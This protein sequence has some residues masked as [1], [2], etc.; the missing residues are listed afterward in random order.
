MTASPLM[1]GTA[2]WSIPRTEAGVFPETGTG[3]CRYAALMTAVE[4][5]TTFYRPHRPATFARWHDSVPPSFRFSV[6]APRTISHELRLS[7]AGAAFAAFTNSLAPL[8]EKLG[9]ILVQLPPSLAFD[10]AT[11]S[12]FL[13]QAAASSPV[14]LVVEPRHVSWFNLDADALLV[15]N[16]VARAG[17]DPERAPGAFHPAAHEGLRYI[18]LHGSPQIYVSAYGPAMFGRLS[19]LAAQSEPLWI[20]FDNTVRG[21]AMHDALHLKKLIGNV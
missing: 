13:R 19:I 21:A 9:A 6:K 1:I 3:L 11:A 20:I 8:G 5:N 17:A 4:I 10:P 16:G 18:R 2:G 7:N 15:A 14:P 12:A